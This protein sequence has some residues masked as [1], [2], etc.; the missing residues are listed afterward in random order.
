MPSSVIKKF[1]Y[2]P[3]SHVLTIT[4]V[5]GVVYDYLDVP[6][7]VYDQMRS[8]L[9]KGVFF[10]DHIKDKYAFVKREG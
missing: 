5:S 3:Q 8:V 6:Q 1:E 9:S 10:N 7:E 4:F 2:N